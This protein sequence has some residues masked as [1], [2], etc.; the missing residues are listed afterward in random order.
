MTVLS[1]RWTSVVPPAREELP[2][3]RAQGLREAQEVL[4]DYANNT[5]ARAVDIRYE[6]ERNGN[7]ERQDQE[8]M[9][10]GFGSFC[11]NAY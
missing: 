10:V 9:R 4:R 5:S 7:N 11:S 1:R 2:L 3:L 6:K 8:Q